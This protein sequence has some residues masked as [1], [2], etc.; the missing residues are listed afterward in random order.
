M[1]LTKDVITLGIQQ[2]RISSL[3]SACFFTSLCSNSQKTEKCDA[4][5]G[6]LDF[7]CSWG[8][9]IAL[10]TYGVGNFERFS[11]TACV[12]TGPEEKEKAMADKEAGEKVQTAAC[13]SNYRKYRRFGAV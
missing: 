4:C 7:L 6:K 10:D 2:Y 8:A 1:K 5:V 9:G 11:G 13:G 12:E 3:V